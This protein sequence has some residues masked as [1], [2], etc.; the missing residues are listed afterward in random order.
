MMNKIFLPFLAII[1]ALFFSSCV[2]NS[3]TKHNKFKKDKTV[4][5]HW[6]NLDDKGL[7]RLSGDDGNYSK[8]SKPFT[9]EAIETFEQ[10][11]T[12]SVS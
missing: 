12:K 6:L 9:G 8:F 1:F 2:K 4:M 5:L 11:P 10:S 3:I 7:V